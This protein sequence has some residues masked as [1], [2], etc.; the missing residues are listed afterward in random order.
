[1]RKVVIRLPQEEL[2]Q[3]SIATILSDLDS[4]IAI[5]SIKINKLTQLK[6]G[7]MRELLTGRIRLMS[8]IENDCAT[9]SESNLYLQGGK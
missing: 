3:Y 5:L 9:I 2:E 4:E 1:L 7:M 8:D 6:Q